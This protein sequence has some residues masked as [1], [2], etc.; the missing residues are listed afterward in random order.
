MR[1]SVIRNGDITHGLVRGAMGHGTGIEHGGQLPLAYPF[2]DRPDREPPSTESGT[3]RR[4][5][6]FGSGAASRSF[7]PRPMIEREPCDRGD[8][9]QADLDQGVDGGEAGLARIAAVGCDPVDVAGSRIGSR[10][11]A[12]CPFSTVVLVTS[13]A[14]G[15]VR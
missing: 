3:L 4:S 14:A 11:D 9:L 7:S 15:A 5:R 13:S 6:P 8:R 1:T 2:P 10:L 12:P